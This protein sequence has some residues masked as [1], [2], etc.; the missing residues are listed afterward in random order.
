M[1]GDRSDAALLAMLIWLCALPLVGLLLVPFFG[2]S[3]GVGAGL[4]LLLI[5]LI[6]CMGLCTWRSPT[7]IVVEEPSGAVPDRRQTAWVRRIYDRRART[8]DLEA[9]LLEPLL[10]PWRQWMWSRVEGPWVL[11]IGIGTGQNFPYYRPGLKIA[12]IDLSPRMVQRARRKAERMGVT[13]QVLPA[14][15]QT[16]PFPDGV[17]NTVMATWVFC[18]VPDPVRGLQEAYRVL[19]PGGRLLLLEHVRAEGW[20]G[21]MMDVLDPLVVRLT[22]AHINR[23]TVEN[24]LRAGFVLEAVET[25]AGIVRRIAAR[26]P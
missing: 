11:E 14:D 6:L 7:L 16:L 5:L 4:G 10:R 19:R 23:R 13:A 24:V 25:S 20:L 22:G 9:G 3:I 26:R 1:A 15:A 8:Y 17:F 18:S 2:W 12:A 21:R